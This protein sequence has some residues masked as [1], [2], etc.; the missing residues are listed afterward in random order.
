MSILE[1]KMDG[2]VAPVGDFTVTRALPQVA[3]RFV[4]PFCFVDHMGP[5]AAVGS[6]DGGVGPHPHIGLST[7]T[8]LFEGEVLHRDSLGTEQLIR[9]GDVNWMTASRGI[10][11]SERT[12]AHLVGKPTSMHGLQVWVGLPTALEEG[13][14]SFQHAPK[15]SLPRLEEN[16]VNAC[17]VLGDYLGEKSPVLVSSPLFYV[18]AELEPG[19]RLELSAQFPERA[20]YVVDGSVMLGDDTLKGRQVGV[21]KTGDEGTVTA[22]T[23]TKLAFFG[24]EPLDGPRFMMWNFVSSRK[25]R[26]EQAKRDW[27][28]RRFPLVPGDEHDRTPFPGENAERSKP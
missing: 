15:S 28:D 18:V 6:V 24:G 4:G 2:K 25:E 26:L 23:S 22:L 9:P 12:P 14:P 21:L 13:D 1:L 27:I 16:G 10:V 3:R 17:V 19:A 7:V 8:Y 5:H 20:V 11:H